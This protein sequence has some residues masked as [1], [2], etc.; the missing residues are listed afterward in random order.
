MEA[1]STLVMALT[2][3]FCLWKTFDLVERLT[4]RIG[5][6]EDELDETDDDEEDEDEEDAQGLGGPGPPYAF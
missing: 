1:V 3:S 6:L 4:K 5:V 2:V